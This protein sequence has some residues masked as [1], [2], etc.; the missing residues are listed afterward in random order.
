MTDFIQKNFKNGV[1]NLLDSE[2]IPID[3]AQDALNWFNQD[4]RNALVGGRLLIGDENGIGKVKG[5]HFGYKV[6]G[7]KVMYRKTADAIQYW[8]GSD[9]IDV[10]TGL[11]DSDVSFANYSSLAGAFTFINGVD[12][13]WK[14][15]NANP[16]SYIS[17]YSSTKNFHGK[18]LIDRGRTVLWDRDD[19]NSKDRTGLYGSWI[20]RQ[21]STVYTPVSSEAIGVSGGTNYTGYLAAKATK[22]FSVLTSDATAPTDLDTVTIGAITYTFKTAIVDAYDVL[23]GGSAAISLD[24]LKSA[25]NL[26]AGIGVTYGIGT[27]IHPTVEATTNTDTTQLLFAKAVGI[28]GNSIVTTEIS[29]HLLFTAGAMD[30]GTQNLIRNVFGVTFSSTVPGGTE[31]FQDDFNGVLTSNL[32]GTGTINYATGEYNIT[33]SDITSVDITSGYQW[34]DSNVKGVSDF[35]KSATRLAGQGFQFPQDEGG[36]PIL[37]ILIG[38]DGAYYSMKSHSSYRLALDETDLLATNLLY[39]KDLGIPYWKCAVSTNRGI[40]FVNTSKPTKPELMILQRDKF[41]VD[42]EP[43]VLMPHFD[44]SLYSYDEAEM[45]SFDRYITIFCK[46]STSTYNDIVLICNLKAKTVDILKFPCQVSASS[47]G[48]FFVG[49]SITENVYQLFS[50]FDDDGL[51]I[52]NFWKS[53]DE[54]YGSENLKKFKRLRVKG[55]IDV[56]QNVEVYMDFDKSGEILIG[57]IRGDGSYVDASASGLIGESQV[58]RVTIGGEPSNASPYFVQL[59]VRTPK[60]R[61]RTITFRAT[62]IGYF[63]FEL[64]I[65]YNIS[66][67]ANKIP[68]RFRQKQNVSTSGTENDL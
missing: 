59:K 9:W 28:S 34:E 56:S 52:E 40:V 26:T 29:T 50:G 43:F 23:I 41:G 55:L 10:I 61:K 14:I 32:G 13:Y 66:K 3:S 22:A 62:G 67:Y 42:V 37:A 48:E 39:R 47:N 65:D 45:N 12:G 49:G 19:E 36:D 53:K 11:T 7:T 18:I 63:D 38:Q 57:T 54:M 25:I 27:L 44:F 30:G 24:N 31:V 4:G 35:T 68:K 21:D 46:S 1:H 33:F 20:D 16:T 6:D 51:V 2:D 8:D 60:F 15:V 17:L 58:G 64:L 5:L